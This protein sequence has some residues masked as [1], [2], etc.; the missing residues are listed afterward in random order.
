MSV[1]KP[2]SVSFG[3]RVVKYTL[4]DNGV[5]ALWVAIT[6]CFVSVGL[7]YIALLLIPLACVSLVFNTSDLL[8]T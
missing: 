1:N 8:R 6:T 3:I 7:S 4:C 2:K 5:I